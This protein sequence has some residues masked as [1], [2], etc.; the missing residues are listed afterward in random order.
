M[1]TKAVW[2]SICGVGRLEHANTLSQQVMLNESTP[3]CTSTAFRSPVLH[4]W[5][6]RGSQLQ[7]PDALPPLM[8]FPL[9][10]PSFAQAIVCKTFFSD[11][12][13][14]LSRIT[15]PLGFA[16]TTMFR[17]LLQYPDS[18]KIKCFNGCVRFLRKP[19]WRYWTISK[20]PRCQVFLK[21]NYIRIFLFY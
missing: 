13:I 1:D 8:S 9:R 3:R 21:S 19:T 16:D 17:E 12:I 4:P 18:P 2:S 10:Q 6:A 15:L 5:T 7:S 20:F 11:I 14:A